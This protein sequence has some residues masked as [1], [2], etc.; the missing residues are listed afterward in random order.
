M[1]RLNEFCAQ[2]VDCCFEKW[3]IHQLIFNGLND[4][5]RSHTKTMYPEGLDYLFTKTP[6]EIWD[7]FEYLAHNTW[8]Y[9]NAREIFSCPSPIP[10]MM[11][12]T[13]LAKSQ[14]EGISYNHS[15][16]PCILIPCDCCDSFNHD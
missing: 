6:D 16:T 9:D 14:F 5:Y 15:H 13:P 11:H 7:F 1:N 2:C 4:K 3:K 8:V 10:Y 12:A